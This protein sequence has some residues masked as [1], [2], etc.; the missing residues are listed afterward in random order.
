MGV[1]DTKSFEEF[2]EEVLENISD[3]YSKVEGSY[4]SDIVAGVCRELEKLSENIASLESAI[5][6]TA[7]SGEYLIRRCADYGITRKLATAAV[8]TVTVTADT[9]TVLK[10]GAELTDSNGKVF[11]ELTQATELTASVP[12]AVTAVCTST[13]KLSIPENSIR[14]VSSVSGI[15][16]TNEAQ[17]SGTDDETDEALF[18]R[19]QFRLQNQPGCGTAADYKRW[20]LEIPGVGYAKV[21]VSA[22]GEITTCIADDDCGP[23]SSTQISAVMANYD[24]KRPLGAVVGVSSATVRYAS[25]AATVQLFDGYSLQEVQAAYEDMLHRYIGEIAFDDRTDVLTLARLSHYLMS[26]DGVED[27]T[28]FTLNNGSS[29]WNISGIIPAF[30][31]TLTA[32]EAK[33]E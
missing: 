21:K 23:V 31:V 25:I 16:I 4:T 1:F 19:L 13:G 18:R 22:T 27:I 29:N 6:V 26:V 7:N 15:V 10:S 33:D 8:I 28:A 2:R 17:I 24:E 11:F 30:A 9:D 5:F 12:T 20:A 14:F 3:R 32:S